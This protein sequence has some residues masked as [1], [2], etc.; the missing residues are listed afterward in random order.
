MSWVG[1]KID[2]G[3]TFRGDG[4]AWWGRAPPPVAVD[5]LER[6]GRFTGTGTDIRDGVLNGS[7]SQK[8]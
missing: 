3:I 1:L 6:L 8:G 7:T 2:N 4:A 5:P